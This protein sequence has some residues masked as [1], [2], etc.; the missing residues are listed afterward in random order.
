MPEEHF[1]AHEHGW[2]A[3]HAT[4]DGG[5]GVGL[6]LFFHFVASGLVQPG[7]CIQAGGGK[8]AGDFFRLGQFAGLAPHGVVEGGDH[9]ILFRGADGGGDDAHGGDG[10]HREVRVHGER[11]L[12][13][14]GVASQV[15]HHVH[16][17][18]R[19]GTG[20]VV[21]GGLED[22]AQQH[23]GINQLGTSAL[24][25]GRQLAPGQ[26]GSGTTHVEEKFDFLGHWFFLSK[27]VVGASLAAR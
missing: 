18:G 16:A 21:A 1:I 3:E 22:T 27:I 14:R 15:A 2:R 13:A 7:L 8:H 11:H 10:I 25:N 9:G 20:R 6:E 24:T 23:R 12:V 19:H 4:L 26:V 17:F 5:L